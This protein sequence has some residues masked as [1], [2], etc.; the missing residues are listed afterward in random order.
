MGLECSRNGGMRHA[1]VHC[2]VSLVSYTHVAYPFNLQ[3]L[4]SFPRSCNLYGFRFFFR[5]KTQCTL[6]SVANVCSIVTS[7]SLI[8]VC[9]RHHV[10][11][12]MP[13]NCELIC[14]PIKYTNA[15]LHRVYMS[16]EFAKEIGE[17]IRSSRRS[18]SCSAAA[19]A[20]TKCTVFAA[21]FL[22]LP[23]C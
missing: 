16:D 19:D 8:S 17:K 3:L 10:A 11:A 5:Y 7:F 6:K 2:T 1:D 15:F 23:V 22:S 13:T 12:H 14:T 20:I 18:I 4:I 21:R 9:F